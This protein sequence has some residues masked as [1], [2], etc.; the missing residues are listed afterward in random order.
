MHINYCELIQLYLVFSGQK[1]FMHPRPDAPN[2]V[3]SSG[4]GNTTMRSNDLPSSSFAGQSHTQQNGVPGTLHGSYASYPYAG[5][6][7]SIYAPHNSQHL[8]AVSY[9]HRP[10]DNFIPSFNVDD[11]RI[12]Q[13]RR[14]PIIHPMDGANVG[15]YYAAS[16]S[17][18]QFSQ[19]VPPNPI[20]APEFW[21]P[22]IPSNFSS[23]HW[24]ENHFSDQGSLRNVR[25]RHDHSSIHLGHGSAVAS[26]SSSTHGP[27]HHANANVP[28]L[29]T[30]MQ[31]DR[32]PFS[33]PPRAA[34]PG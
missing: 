1:I 21:P 34:P 25:G 24:S 5:S 22:P 13:K 19:H 4:Y 31:Q 7:N 8:P 2:G 6:S 28:S 20:P 14:N 23:S 11:R 12:A 17:N 10:E 32:A 15:R 27:P 26:S 9:Q 30:S 18:S 16:S 29:N 33:I 3:I